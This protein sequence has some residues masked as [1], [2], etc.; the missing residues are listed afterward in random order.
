MAQWH[1]GGIKLRIV[2]DLLRLRRQYHD[3]FAFGSYAGLHAT[4]PAGDRICAFFRAGDEGTMVVAAALLP[5][6][7]S[8]EGWGDSVVPMPAGSGDAWINL[9]DGRR[10][11]RCGGAFAAAELFYVLPVA[12]LVPERRVRQG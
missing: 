4:G 3:L 11:A 8:L 2:S 6:R 1:N 12:V 10:I 5:Q 7:A 9:F